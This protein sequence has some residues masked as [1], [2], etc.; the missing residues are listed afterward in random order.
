M[1]DKELI[2]QLDTSELSLIQDTYLEI[3]PDLAARLNY[4]AEELEEATNAVV[5][6]LVKTFISLKIDSKR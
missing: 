2:K 6:T 5:T 4:G 1:L 3:F